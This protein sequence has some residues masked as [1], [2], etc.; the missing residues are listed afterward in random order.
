MINGKSMMW[1]EINL[2]RMV[3]KYLLITAKK[4]EYLEDKNI[5]SIDATSRCDMNDREDG[6]YEASGIIVLCIYVLNKQQSNKE[7][8]WGKKTS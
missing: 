2:S 5:I 6:K 3:G 1:N 8:A 4:S 7:W